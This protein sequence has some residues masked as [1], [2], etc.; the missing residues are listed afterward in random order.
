M[1]SFAGLGDAVAGGEV[2][3]GGESDGVSTVLGVVTPTDGAASGEL[4][5][6]WFGWVQPARIKTNPATHVAGTT[7]L[8][9]RP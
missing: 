5:A 4:V 1:I 7:P 6:V 9:T 3:G 8:L 2:A